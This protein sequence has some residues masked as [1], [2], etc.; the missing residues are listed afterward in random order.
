[1]DCETEQKLAPSIPHTS[2]VAALPKATATAVD[3][4]DVQEHAMTFLWSTLFPAMHPS[5]IYCGRADV[6]VLIST[7]EISLP[8]VDLVALDSSYLFSI[9]KA[10][11]KSSPAAQGPT[12]HSSEFITC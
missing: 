10:E 8:L 4:G 9:S 11:V 7:Q 2:D 1:M 12:S 5:G 6:P 3:Q